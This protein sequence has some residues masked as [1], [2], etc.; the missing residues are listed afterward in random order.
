MLV[1]LLSVASCLLPYAF[2][3]HKR[4]RGSNQFATVFAMSMIIDRPHVFV[5]GVTYFLL[6]MLF[7]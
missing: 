1:L 7:S 5:S 6:T 2:G 3:D 4:Q